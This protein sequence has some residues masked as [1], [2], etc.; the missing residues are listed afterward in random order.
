VLDP[1]TQ[2]RIAADF[3]FAYGEPSA[4]MQ[5]ANDQSSAPSLPFIAP[6]D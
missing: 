6:A 2:F 5:Q 4:L 1:D 3:D